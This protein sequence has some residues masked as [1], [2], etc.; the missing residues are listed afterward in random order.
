M[1]LYFRGLTLRIKIWKTCWSIRW[2]SERTLRRQAPKKTRASRLRQKS[3]R[4]FDQDSSCLW[5][6]RQRRGFILT[7]GEQSD[8]RQVDNLIKDIAFDCLIAD[9]GYDSEPFVQK[10]RLTGR[11]VVI[12]KRRYG[13]Q[14]RRKYDRH[15]YRERHL[16]ECFIGKIKHYRRIF[17]R[18]EKLSKNYLSF[19]HLVSSLIWLRWNVNRT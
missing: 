10:V 13:S 15:L 19:V 17:T 5:C 11:R 9:K 1:A 3:R 6:A 7:G 12:P 16:I 14:S 8:Y 18:F 4:L 2:L